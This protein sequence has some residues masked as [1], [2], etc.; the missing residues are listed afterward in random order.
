MEINVTVEFP[1]MELLADALN[2]FADV[3]TNGASEHL[4]GEMVAAIEK[5][6]PEPQTAAAPVAPTTPAPVAQVNP[7]PAPAATQTAS[8]S[9]ATATAPVTPAV[10]AQTNSAPVTPAPTAPV[11]APTYT[12]DQLA[13]AATDTFMPNRMADLTNLLAS[14]GVASL[15]DLPEARFGEFAT[16][17]RGMGA[18]I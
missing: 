4:A 6:M 10:P 17:L 12:R 9:T 14:F 1:A 5:S 7:T 13:K 2:R 18:V 16:A 3:L 15:M 11:A 8:V